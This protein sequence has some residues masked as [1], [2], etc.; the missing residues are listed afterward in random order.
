MCII[1]SRPSAPAD[2]LV[3]PYPTLLSSTRLC[4]SLFVRVFSPP[5]FSPIS[6]FLLPRVPHLVFS[7]PQGCSPSPCFIFLRIARSDPH[8]NAPHSRE[9]FHPGAA[10]EGSATTTGRKGESRSQGRGR[11]WRRPEGRQGERAGNPTLTSNK[12]GELMREGARADTCGYR[13]N[14][15]L[16]NRVPADPRKTFQLNLPS[17]SFSGKAGPGKIPRKNFSM[18]PALRRNFQDTI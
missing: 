8:T 1:H 3:S 7:S 17:S 16:S 15:R 12:G 6:D 9:H 5:F 18:L 11:V 10:K 4:F 2:C 13:P 14:S